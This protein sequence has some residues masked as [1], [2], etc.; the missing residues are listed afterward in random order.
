MR[1]SVVS[2]SALLAVSALFVPVVSAQSAEAPKVSFPAAS[3]L[4]VLKQ[5]VGLTDI[6]ITYS[7]PG[8]KG[9]EIFGALEA[10]GKIW[11]TG[12]NNATKLKFSTPVKL[13][14]AEIPAGTYEL[15][16][17][18]DPTEWTV[19][20]HKDSS[21]WGA[22]KYDEKNDV[23][24]VKA[25]PVKL[26]QPVETFTIDLNDLRNDSATLNLVWETTRVPVK[27]EVDTAS[28]LVPQI[29]A[30][31]ASPA[32]KSA[33]FY[34]NAAQFYYDQ[35]LDLNKAKAFITEA[36]SGEKPAFY[37]VHWKAKILARLGEKES[38]IA[39]AKQSSELAI[40]AEGPQSGF[41]KMNNDLIASLK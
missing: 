30:A 19:I 12:A 37:M 39:A 29:E 2:S 6:E 3:P 18:P 31:L 16:T 34:Y 28:V 14:G 24:R 26:A 41:V 35:G 27:L 8:M 21:Q 25:K 15:F 23:A 4:C 11:R 1:F 22:Y 17:I 38:A 40:A 33:G 10:Y 13:N 7:R 36:T 5:R 20:I 32:K 9:R